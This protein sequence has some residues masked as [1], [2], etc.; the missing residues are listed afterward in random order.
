MY[1][2]GSYGDKYDDDRYGSRDE[3]RNGY[4]Y[5]RERE[6]G[7]RDDDRYGRYGD[8]NSRDGDRYEERYSR[9]GYKDDDYRGRSRSVDDFQD[10]SRSRSFDRDRDRA[11]DDD[12]QYSSRYVSISMGFYVASVIKNHVAFHGSILLL[13]SHFAVFTCFFGWFSFH[14]E[15]LR[16][17]FSFKKNA[18]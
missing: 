10:G 1:K 9:D 15:Y 8:S 2:P 12:G 3:D 14:F 11:F 16:S 17:N 5:G 4:G 18:T 13:P 7:Y 6:T